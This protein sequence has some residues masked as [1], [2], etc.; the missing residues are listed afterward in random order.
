[1]NL[2]ALRQR[3]ANERAGFERFQGAA[4]LTKK[5]PIEEHP[6]LL[7]IIENVVLKDES[8]L[9]ACVEERKK[10]N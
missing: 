6:G 8:D 3:W 7:A 5:S 4:L 2:D 10:A 1:V 9:A